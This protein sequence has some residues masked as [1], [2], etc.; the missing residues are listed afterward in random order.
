[1]YCPNCGSNNQAEIKFCTQCGTN[2]N[3][4][5]EALSGKSATHPKLDER[6]EIALKDYYASRRAVLIAA[7]LIPVGAAILAM[8]SILGFPE[9]L[10]VVALIGL[11][12]AITVYGASVGIWGIRHWIDSTS[13][14]KVLKL[15]DS[16][17]ALPLASEGQAS[18]A[19]AALAQHY[20]TD[21][22]GPGSVTEQTTR[23]LEESPAKPPLEI[24]S[25]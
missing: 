7:L 12:I 24:Q 2:L 22:I 13:E 5:S 16:P 17:A 20:A 4:V 23:Q 14:M 25:E 11:G 21:P 6:M 1:V 15:T 10:A 18:I 19:P 9:T 3:I 8:M